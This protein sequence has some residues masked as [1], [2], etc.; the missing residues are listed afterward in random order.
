ML[1]VFIFVLLLLIVILIF[2]CDIKLY[3]TICDS[4]YKVTICFCILEKICIYKGDLNSLTK[5]L[6]KNKPKAI[7]NLKS[8]IRLIRRLNIIADKIYAKIY[9]GTSEVQ[10]T[11]I[12]TGILNSIIGIIISG[13]N[14]KITKDNLKYRVFPIYSSKKVFHVKIKCIFSIGLVHIISTFIKKKIGDVRNGR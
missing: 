11:A 13:L 6:N 8:V 5:R 10:S 9:I 4:G 7:F 3:I 1:L 2:S 14:V 12:I